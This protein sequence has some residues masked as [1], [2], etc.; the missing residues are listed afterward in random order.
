MKS[1]KVAILCGGKGVRL[2]PL[3]EQIPKPLIT[4]GGKPII[5]HLIE[6]YARQNFDEFFLCVGHL[7]NKI[8]AYFKDK[9]QFNI[10][11]VD[12]G[13][14]ATPL[15]RIYDLRDLFED[16]MLISYGDTIADINFKEFL[17]VHKSSN[18]LV[19]ILTAPFV[20]PFGLVTWHEDDCRLASFEEKPVF[21]YYV[22]YFIMKK[23]AFEYITPEMLSQPLG[24][25]SLFNAFINEK[26]L[27]G[28]KHHGPKIT[29]N[30]DH[31]LMHAEKLILDFYTVKE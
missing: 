28:Y 3:T 24:L 23:E 6:L 11:F 16:Q 27:A 26:K 2:Q 18:A 1:T 15:Q 19:T 14:E 9:N 8:E 12:S 31:E 30:T 22:G 10:K 21:D 20:S 5:E 29:F 4:L 13:T 17:D 7:G 25:I